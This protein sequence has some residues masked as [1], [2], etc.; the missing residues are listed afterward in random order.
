MRL[1]LDECVPARVRRE[2]ASHIMV[3]AAQVERVLGVHLHAQPA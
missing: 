1:L 2:F 3:N